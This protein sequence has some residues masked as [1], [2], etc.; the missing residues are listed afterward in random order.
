MELNELV[1]YILL[2]VLLV[3]IGCILGIFNGYLSRWNLPSWYVSN[4]KI[5]NFDLNPSTFLS[6]I[7]KQASVP[8]NTIRHA[9]LDNQAILDKMTSRVNTINRKLAE[10]NIRNSDANNNPYSVSGNLVFY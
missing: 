7:I 9:A 3:I 4:N 1:L 10:A 2:L 8:I 6:D 5:E